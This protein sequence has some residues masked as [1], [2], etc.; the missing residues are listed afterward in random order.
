VVEAV[1]NVDDN[2]VIVVVDD[3]II[4]AVVGDNIV[5]V[6]VRGSVDV[7]VATDV[8]A[9]DDDGVALVVSGSF[10]AR[11]ANFN[12]RERVTATIVKAIKDM[13]TI[14]AQR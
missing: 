7:N 8:V 3:N 9:V 5:V 4:V 10:G 6:V 2:V 14:L 13:A 11:I 1:V 12:T